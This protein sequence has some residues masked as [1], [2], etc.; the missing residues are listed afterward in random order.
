MD[1]EAPVELPTR[2]SGVLSTV[3]STPLPEAVPEL[4]AEQP[5]KGKGLEATDGRVLV[6]K[7]TGGIAGVDEEWIIYA[8][9]SV[10][11][12]DGGQQQV[13]P[14][15]VQAIVDMA[16]N[17]DSKGSYTPINNCCDLFTYTITVYTA[18]ATKS[19]TTTDGAKQPVEV[20]AVFDK[21]GQL[22]A[23]SQR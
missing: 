6:Y 12:P 8:D 16:G 14:Q 17:M 10:L 23:A 11:D 4:L 19:V 7:R 1:Q 18:E 21:I 13:D 9:G 2:V 3:T 20:T 22:L 15:Q 5:E